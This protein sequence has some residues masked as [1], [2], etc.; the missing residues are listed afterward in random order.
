MLILTNFLLIDLSHKIPPNVDHPKIQ[1]L[2]TRSYLNQYNAALCHSHLDIWSHRLEK[3]D[4]LQF[5]YNLSYY[6][7][8]Y[9]FL[10]IFWLNLR[11]SKNILKI[12]LN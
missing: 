2:L 11:K 5:I 7:F 1:L 9:L 3:I 10:S 4:K 12:Y 8:C 6:N